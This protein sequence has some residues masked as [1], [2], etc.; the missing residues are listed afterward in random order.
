MTREITEKEH[1]E[2]CI[3]LNEWMRIWNKI[4]SNMKTL[5][6]IKYAAIISD[7]LSELLANDAIQYG[8]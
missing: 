4:P 8:L 5:E 6:R 1:N 2:L 3:Y 7:N